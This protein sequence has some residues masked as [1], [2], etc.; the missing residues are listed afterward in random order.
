[1]YFSMLNGALDGFMAWIESLFSIIP[2]YFY[3]LITLVYNLLDVLQLL[4]RKMAGLDSVYYI[5]TGTELDTA[6]GEDIII[7]ILQQQEVKDTLVAMLVLG[8]ILVLIFTII[9]ILRTEFNAEDSKSASK[10]RVVGKSIRAL[11][12]M[13]FVPV[14]CYLGFFLSNAILKALDSATVQPVT[15]LSDTASEVLLP[16]YNYYIFGIA[17][18]TNSTPLSGMAFRAATFKANRIRNDSAYATDL[19]LSGNDADGPTFGGAFNPASGGTVDTLGKNRAANALDD[20]F[21]NCY[22]LKDTSLSLNERLD[23]GSSDY[24]KKYATSVILFVGINN[25][26]LS[27][28][29]KYN[30]NLVWFFYDLWKFDWILAIGIVLA[31][32][33]IFLNLTLGLMKRI[34]DLIILLIVS[35]PIAATLVLD[36]GS[37]SIYKK[38]RGKFIGKTIAAYGPVVSMNLFFII[39]PFIRNISFFKT[40]ADAELSVVSFADI[41]V[42]SF[43]IIVGLVAIQDISKTLSGMVG[44]EDAGEAGGKMV[45]DAVGTALKVAAVAS[46]TGALAAKAMKGGFR[47]GKAGKNAVESG[48]Q[49]LK[50]KSN[51]KEANN[52]E[53]EAQEEHQEQISKFLSNGGVMS[54]R[55]RGPQSARNEMREA[56][57]KYKQ[58]MQSAQEKHEKAKEYNEKSSGSIKRAKS[59]IV[60]AG[61]HAAG[62]VSTPASMLGIITKDN[63]YRKA[64]E[65]GFKDLSNDLTFGILGKLRSKKEHNS[66]VTAKMEELKLKKKTEDKIIK[67][68]KKNQK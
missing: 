51:E 66:A 1:M 45:G 15:E 59:D 7:K 37:N 32:T 42:Q 19:A 38:W 34:F 10:T 31:I 50:A 35:P 9:A 41:I 16:S 25:I 11:L 56:D 44:A 33:V 2:K 36:D 28:I 14:I 12:L 46:G 18:E 22:M 4:F 43:F 67:E 17:I 64:G 6:G 23:N 39:V 40:S 62:V 27:C 21:V 61:K 48:I 55:R 52:I 47:A 5:T 63:P 65:A 68:E 24:I 53:K 58:K 29:S 30:V 20:A 54:D 8:V 49:K 60:L 57:N 13:F 26:N 3:L